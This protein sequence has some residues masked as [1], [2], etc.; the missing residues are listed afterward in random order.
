MYV[1]AMTSPDDPAWAGSG[2]RLDELGYVSGGSD[3][4]CD[5][6]AA[7]ALGLAD[8]TLVRAVYF[9]SEAE[10]RAFVDLYGAV[11]GVVP[12]RTLCLD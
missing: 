11:L 6:G 2:A 9:A 1:A 5:V 3:V 8:N 4:S 10:A 12:V 7:A